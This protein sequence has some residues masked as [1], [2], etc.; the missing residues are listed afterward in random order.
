MEFFNCFNYVYL[1][2]PAQKL[3]LSIHPVSIHLFY[4]NVYSYVCFIIRKV[5][6]K[7]LEMVPQITLFFALS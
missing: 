3:V 5:N 7:L 6:R 1:K 4:K 2:V